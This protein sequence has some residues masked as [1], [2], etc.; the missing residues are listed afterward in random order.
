MPPN[1]KFRN[2]V[3]KKRRFTGSQHTKKKDLSEIDAPTQD[4][5]SSYE[6]GG[7]E[8]CDE[9]VEAASFKCLPPSVRK[10]DTVKR[11]LQRK[12]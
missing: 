10:M 11:F 9:H 2:A 1:K 7:E 12:Y 5:A 4:E 8:L 6:D 3:R